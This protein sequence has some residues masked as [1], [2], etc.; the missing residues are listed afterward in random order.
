MKRERKLLGFIVNPI[1]GMGGRVGLKGTDG[2]DTPKTAIEL[3]ASSESPRRALEAL[4]VVARARDDVELITYPREMGEDVA[5]TAGFEPRVIG[6]V[7]H[8]R[9]TAAD[10]ER[11]ASE[12]EAL[13]VELLLFAGGDGTARDIYRAVG[14]R[15]TVLGIPTGVKM[16]SAVFALSPRVAGEVV[17][18]FLS[19]PHPA[20]TEGEVMDI[21]EASFRRGRL[22]ARLYGYMRVPQ[23]RQHLQGPKSG[24]TSTER[25]VARGIAT[26][27]FRVMESEK[28]EGWM[29]IVG[30]GSTTRDVLAQLHLR[31][32]LLGVDV[33]A[34]GRVVAYDA[35]ESQLVD[36]LGKG[37]GRAKVVVTPIGGQG[38]IFGRGNQQIS[39][40]VLGRVGRENIVVVASKQKLA[41]LGGR[42]LL[43]DT[44]DAEVDRSLEGYARVIVGLGEY[45]MCRVSR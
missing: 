26:E 20:T 43:V 1:A 3:G 32:T 42:P 27:L 24:G 44:G 12:M 36:L 17:V 23:E 14:H 28:A 8:G 37:A 41:S 7:E 18:S 35:N 6:E 39:G 45:V 9:S 16:H 13:G 21:D 31:K 5:R 11:A 4:N 15:V 10:T 33:V 40:R 29:Y 2:R 34:D 30:P 22:N 25:Q 38:Y 19:A